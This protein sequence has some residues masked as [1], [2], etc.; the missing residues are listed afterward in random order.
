MNDLA[1]MAANRRRESGT[2][3]SPQPGSTEVFL[4]TPVSYY[5]TST[6]TLPSVHE[7]TYLQLYVSSNVLG[8]LL[9]LCL[10]KEKK[11]DHQIINFILHDFLI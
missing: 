11:L 9:E 10:N 2:D 8:K 3:L 1:N 5:L 6:E 7:C 4:V